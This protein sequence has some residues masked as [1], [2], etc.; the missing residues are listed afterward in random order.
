MPSAGHLADD[1]EAGQHHEE[2][3]D[4]V[5]QRRGVTGLAERHEAQQ[6]VAGVG[7]AGEAEQALEVGLGQGDQVA[8]EHRGDRQHRQ[9]QA[10]V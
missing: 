9:Q 1:H 8:V 5:V 3:A 7:D 10:K 2:V 6:R 4:D